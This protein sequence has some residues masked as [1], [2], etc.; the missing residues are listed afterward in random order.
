MSYQR[1][2]ELIDYFETFERDFGDQGISTFAY[3]LNTEVNG[4]SP[5]PNEN[6]DDEINEQVFQ[7][8]GILA[9]HARHYVK[10]MVKDTP[11]SGWNDLIVVMVLYYRREKMRKSDLI[12]HSLIDLS[13]G[14]ETLKRLL[15][16]DLLQAFEDPKDRRAK[17]VGLTPISE[18]LFKTVIEKRITQVAK[19]IAG[20]LTQEEKQQLLPILFKLVHFHEPIFMEDYG[21]A[22]EVLLEKYI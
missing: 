20:N 3:W 15:K 6:P 2:K 5:D 11:L 19:I 8:L 14:T 7:A 1:L 17:L 10:T 9:S 13:A 21:S 18:T 16:Q 22:I 4:I 12:R